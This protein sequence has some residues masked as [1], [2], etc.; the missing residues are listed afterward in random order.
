MGC[1]LRAA[2]RTRLGRCVSG[3]RSCIA[4]YLALVFGLNVAMQDLTLWLGRASV[5][6]V[7][8]S[9]ATFLNGKRYRGRPHATAG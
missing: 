5:S 9:K 6:L 4:T 2:A 8:G 3:V 7:R 1:A